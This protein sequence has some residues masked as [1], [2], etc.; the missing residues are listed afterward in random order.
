MQSLA[1]TTMNCT[2][3]EGWEVSFDVHV[4]QGSHAIGEES[5]PQDK[6][7]LGMYEYRKKRKKKH[8]S[9]FRP[10]TKQKSQLIHIG[11][12]HLVTQTENETEKR[13]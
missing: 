3:T 7:M 11:T 8:D 6:I 10:N 1:T 4:I 2:V 9:Y 12:A 5:S 13:M